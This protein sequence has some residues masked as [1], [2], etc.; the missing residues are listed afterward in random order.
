MESSQTAETWGTFSL[1]A[2]RAAQLELRQYL[3]DVAHRRTFFRPLGPTARVQIPQGLGH[4]D[5][6]GFVG[7]V[8][9]G[10]NLKFR[11]GFYVP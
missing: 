11:N 10:H 1:L 3:G 2:V 7:T 9:L 4:V 5:V 8:R 6:L